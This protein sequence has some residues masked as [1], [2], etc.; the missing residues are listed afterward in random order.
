MSTTTSQ[1]EA[2]SAFEQAIINAFKHKTHKDIYSYITIAYDEL[3]TYINDIKASS[4]SSKSILNKNI[5]S[6]LSH[7]TQRNYLVITMITFPKTFLS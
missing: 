6:K 4:S 5:L 3:H 2:K 1:T 7:I